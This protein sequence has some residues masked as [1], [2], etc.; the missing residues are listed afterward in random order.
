MFS[1]F[2]P[3]HDTR[4]LM[5]RRN[6][7]SFWNG[8]NGSVIR[9]KCGCGHEGFLDNTGSHADDTNVNCPSG[10]CDPIAINKSGDSAENSAN[11][12]AD[13]PARNPVSSSR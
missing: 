2:C 3:T 4:V 11:N 5:T 13:N 7:V 6:A 12:S 8:P 1:V 10:D 9:W